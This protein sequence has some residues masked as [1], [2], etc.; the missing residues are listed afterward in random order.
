MMNLA[1][2]GYLWLLLLLIP[3]V[4]YHVMKERRGYASVRLSSTRAFAKTGLGVKGVLRHV[5]FA[6]K[7]AAFACLVLILCRPQSYDRWAT[8]ETQGTDI[9]MAVDISAS[10][11]S[12]DLKPDRLSAARDVAKAFVAKRTDDNIGLVIFAGDG[13]TL[14]PMTTDHT[15]LLNSLQELDVRLLDSD[16]TAIGDGIATAI[17]RIRSGKAKSKSIILITDGTNNTGVIAPLTAAEV[18]KKDGIK[19]YTIGVG[20]K[21]MAP[22]PY[23]QDL[24]GNLIFKP[25]PVTIDEPTL[26]KVASMT[27][28]KYY[29]ATD[30]S[31]LDQV[32][33]EIDKLEKTTLDVQNFSNTQDHYEPWAWALLALL[34]VSLLLDYTVLRRLP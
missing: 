25:M 17:N 23:A 34:V 33:A 13:F 21:G 18:A 10:M 15:Q 30:N 4:A 27:G 7:A 28:G 14:M 6:L 5:S 31:V 12:Q 1:H 8:S 3:L 22:T 26:Q 20:T 9:V 16:G 29:R 11:L 2:P 24:A 32:F 19:I